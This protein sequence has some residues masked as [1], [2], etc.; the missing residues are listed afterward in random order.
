[1]YIKVDE[2]LEDVSHIVFDGEKYKVVDGYA[3][4]PQNV[5]EHLTSFPIWHS[6]NRAVP[7]NVKAAFEKSEEKADE[8][9]KKTAKKK[10]K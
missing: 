5:A 2:Q 4:V 7:E 6:A 8:E 1:M 10:S 9:E 3:S